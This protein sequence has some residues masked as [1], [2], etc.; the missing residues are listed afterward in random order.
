MEVGAP[1]LAVVARR[2]DFEREDFVEACAGDF[3]DFLP[4]VEL[5]FAI[6]GRLAAQPRK[7][8]IEAGC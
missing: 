2:G 8:Q 7:F 1:R 6:A 5:R 3:L 4:L